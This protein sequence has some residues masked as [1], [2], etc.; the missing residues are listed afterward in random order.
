[1][2]GGA[3]GGVVVV[4]VV[5]VEVEVVDALMVV[6]VIIGAAVVVGNCGEADGGV[7]G[8]VE[9]EVVEGADAR[10]GGEVEVVEGVLV[11]D[12]VVVGG[13]GHVVDGGVV[14]LAVGE[15]VRDQEAEIR[16]VGGGGVGG[17]VGIGQVGCVLLEVDAE[18]E[19][20]EVGWL[21]R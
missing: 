8:Q 12:V 21:C 14:C 19:G 1:M 4:V 18:E 15:R 7:E 5:V 2:V 3:A 20:E 17:G 11:V 10:G 13:C 9:R 16:C 6:I